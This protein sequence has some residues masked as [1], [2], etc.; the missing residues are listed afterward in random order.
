MLGTIALGVVISLIVGFGIGYAAHTSS[1]SSKKAKKLTAAQK[2]KKRQQ[3]QGER[4]EEEDRRRARPDRRDLRGQASHAS[5]CSTP[6]T[7][8]CESPSA[9]RPAS[10]SPRRAHATSIVVGSKVLFRPSTKD[11]TKATQVVVLPAEG[12]DR[13]ARDSPSTPG[14]SL[15]VKSLNGAKKITTKGATVWV[16]VAGNKKSLVRREIVT[17]RYF[18]VGAK[19]TPTATQVV[20]MPAPPKAG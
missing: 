16:T 7:R 4:Q 2:K 15:T 8:A 5:P 17:V 9:A 13:R 19:K 11:P 1:G 18:L 3:D 12:A 6:R 14:K 10:T 20:V